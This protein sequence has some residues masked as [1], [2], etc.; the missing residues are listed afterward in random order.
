MLYCSSAPESVSIRDS[1]PEYL[2]GV[3]REYPVMNYYIDEIILRE[4]APEAAVTKGE[5]IL[6]C[7]EH[8]Y[9]LDYLMHDVKKFDTAGQ[10]VSTYDVK[11]SAA[12]E[13]L[14]FS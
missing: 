8:Y 10:Y 12:L 13:Y 1:A 11:V 9:T 2:I 7:T 5:K 4:K 14:T 3:D 6:E